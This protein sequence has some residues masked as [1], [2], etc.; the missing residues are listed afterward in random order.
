[1]QDN[2]YNFNQLL[3]EANLLLEKEALPDSQQRFLELAVLLVIKLIDEL[4]AQG[5]LSEGWVTFRPKLSW[6]QF[7]SLEPTSMLQALNQVI[8]PQLIKTYNR[9]TDFFPKKSKL[10]NPVTLKNLVDKL[11]ALNLLKL[12]CNILGE[13]FEY[14]LQ[15]GAVHRKQSLGIYFTPYHI[16]RLILDLI[17]FKSTDTIY[18]PTCGAGG[19]LIEAYQLLKKQ[20]KA[21]CLLNK[22]IL[23]GR[24]I[25]DSIKLAKLNLLLRGANPSSICQMDTLKAPIYNRFSVVL[26]NFP[27]SQETA[28]SAVYG[29]KGKEA[30]PVF[31]KHIIDAL[32]FGGIAAVIVPDRLLFNKNLDYIKVRKLL[33]ETCQ[34]LGIIHLHEFVFMPYTKQPTSIL[35]FKK[36]GSTQRVWFFEV[37]DD[38]FKK[39]RSLLS[40]N[41]RSIQ[42]N[43]LE[44]LK[45]LWK[46]KA[47][48]PRSFSVDASNIA[49]E[50]YHLSMHRYRRLSQYFKNGIKLGELCNIVIGQTPRK[51]H[52]NFYNGNHLFVRM[53]DLNQR[54]ITDT[55]LKLTDEGVSCFSLKSLKKHSLLLS[56]RFTVGKTAFVGKKLYTSE[57][58]AGILPK[59]NRVLSQYLYYIL[60]QLDYSPYT[61]RNVKGPELTSATL[62]ALYI[63]LPP[64][65]VQKQLVRLF[66]SQEA[67]KQRYL[68][69]INQLVS[70]KNKKIQAL[71]KK[72]QRHGSR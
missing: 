31:L 64:L 51:T 38:G 12:K 40:R 6:A 65:R 59:D 13:V 48:S 5:L 3:L 44:L 39:T 46:N 9:Y 36:G 45:A 32:M 23:F 10:K 42:E 69:K 58:I 18:D 29:L 1:M 67:K 15:Q 70:V 16:V 24:E 41:S 21:D 22:K 47:D 63:P 19:F 20:S 34:V 17:K 27:F 28:Y 50:N 66:D 61:N 57:A 33:L 52:A 62:A 53:G 14:F 56:L 49:K 26:A 7:S 11:S 54:I 60:P 68:K 35:I 37:I 43:D 25:S 30:N 55:H 71:L 8:L 2:P 4:Q 72:E